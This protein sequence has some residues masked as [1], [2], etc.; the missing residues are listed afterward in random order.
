[1]WTFFLLS[2]HWFYSFLLLL[3]EMKQKLQKVKTEGVLQVKNKL[4]RN[5]CDQGYLS[6][7]Y[8]SIYTQ[9]HTYIYSCPQDLH[10]FSKIP[11]P[12]SFWVLRNLFYVM[13]LYLPWAPACVFGAVDQ[14]LQFCGLPPLTSLLP[15]GT[16]T[17]SSRKPIL[18]NKS[19]LDS[20]GYQNVLAKLGVLIKEPAGAWGGDSALRGRTGN[21]SASRTAVMHRRHWGRT[22]GGG[23]Q[24]APVNLSSSCYKSCNNIW[25]LQIWK[26]KLFF[27]IRIQIGKHI[28]LQA[29]ENEC[30]PPHILCPWT[31]LNWSQTYISLWWLHQGMF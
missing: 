11:T 27:Y 15:P 23:R 28:S 3:L 20:N 25:S 14:N 10:G 19:S 22:R 29:L 12:R 26:E 4:R 16:F 5:Y 31:E 17:F 1:M 18:F 9:T 21:W 6:L 2:K 24:R 7:W 30:H 13:A 8:I